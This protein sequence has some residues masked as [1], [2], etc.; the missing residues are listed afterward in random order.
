MEF[1]ENDIIQDTRMNS[2]ELP[3]VKTFYIHIVRSPTQLHYDFY[4][5]ESCR[6]SGRLIGPKLILHLDICEPQFLITC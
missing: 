3:P 6:V 4:L 1:L 5:Y 2:N